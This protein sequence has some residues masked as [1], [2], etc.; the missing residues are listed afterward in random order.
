MKIILCFSSVPFNTLIEYS[1][2]NG[3][4]WNLTSKFFNPLSEC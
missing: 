1:A 2:L 4:N 3:K